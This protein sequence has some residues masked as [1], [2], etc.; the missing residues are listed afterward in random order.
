LYRYD[1]IFLREPLSAAEA[2]QDVKTREGVDQAVAGDGVCYFARLVSRATQSYLNRIVALP[3][4]Q[5]MT[6]RNW[7][8][9]T[10]LLSLLDARSE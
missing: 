5:S 7:N 2:M 9:T 6:I 1:V 10:K 3:V 4:Y 8:T